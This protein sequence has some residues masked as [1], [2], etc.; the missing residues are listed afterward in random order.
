MKGKNMRIL[1][2]LSVLLG[3]SVVHAADTN[4]GHVEVI[5]RTIPFDITLC[6]KVWNTTASPYSSCQVDVPITNELQVL[7]ARR[8][9]IEVVNGI[10]TYYAYLHV[11]SEV[12]FKNKLTYSATVTKKLTGSNYAP[13]NISF[14][15]A[16]STLEALLKTLPFK[17]EVAALVLIKEE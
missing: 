13:E 15:E 5:E 10:Y 2:I 16:K 7:S 6:E 14:S 17:E 1:L 8:S 9:S 11:D 12:Y 3:A 4:F